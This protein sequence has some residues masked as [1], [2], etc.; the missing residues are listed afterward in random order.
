VPAIGAPTHTQSGHKWT[1]VDRSGQEWTFG[2]YG[3]DITK[4]GDIT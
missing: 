1:Q 3:G 4:P 2:V